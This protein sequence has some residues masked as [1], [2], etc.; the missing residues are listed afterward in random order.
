MSRVAN[1]RIVIL[2][3]IVLLGFF[4]YNMDML[5]S[6]CN[7]RGDFLTGNSYCLLTVRNAMRKNCRKAGR[8]IGSS[9][10]E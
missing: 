4:N 9:L 3:S 10:K 6:R 1:E 7:Q 8:R 2:L 5:K